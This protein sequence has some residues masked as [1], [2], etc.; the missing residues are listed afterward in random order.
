VIAKCPDIG[1][2]RLEFQAQFI[3]HIVQFQ[4]RKV[5]LTGLWTQ[6]RKLRDLNSDRVVALRIGVIEGF[7]R[8]G[9]GFQIFWTDFQAHSINPDLC[10]PVD[11]LVRF[12][13]YTTV[14]GQTKEFIG[15]SAVQ[16]AC[17]GTVAGRKGLFLLDCWFCIVSSDRGEQRVALLASFVLE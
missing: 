11:V 1:L 7:Q 6:A 9:W 4:H 17:R 14:R 13:L 12:L 15:R 8:K 2:E 16:E 3:R 10:R 5:G